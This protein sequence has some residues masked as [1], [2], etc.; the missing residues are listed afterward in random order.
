MD[1]A[2]HFH[3]LHRGDR[4]LLLP[5]AMDAGSAAMFAGMGFDAIATT[6]GGIAWSL[7]TCSGV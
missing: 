4:P 2:R 7:A 1:K 3:A 5:N 6:S